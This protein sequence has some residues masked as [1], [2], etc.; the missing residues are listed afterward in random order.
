MFSPK[1][2]PSF[3]LHLDL[4][5]WLTRYGVFDIPATRWY[6]GH[7]LK[8]LEYIHSRGVLHRDLKPENVM[9]D[10]Q[11]AIKLGDFGSSKLA[12][13]LGSRYIWGNKS[14]TFVGTAQYVAPEI[15]NAQA[16]SPAVDFWSLGCIIFR[17][18]AGDVP[19]QV[20]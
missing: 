14:S 9:L 13:Q 1:I 19:F 10:D 11:M 3:L 2:T 15:L 6:A 7:I 20:I 12:P 16:L 5:C 4:S 8:A 18:I 17:M